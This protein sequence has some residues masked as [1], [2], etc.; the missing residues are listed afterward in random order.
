MVKEER[1]QAFTTVTADVSDNIEFYGEFGVTMNTA[2]RS[3]SPSFP[4]VTFPFVPANNPGN[5]LGVPAIM[6][7]RILGN[8][9]PENISDHNNDTYRAVAALSG[10]FDNNWSGNLSV[11]YSWHKNFFAVSDQLTDRTNAAL[12]GFGG[13]GGD[14]FLMPFL[15]IPNDPALIDYVT[16]RFQITTETSLLTVDAVVTGEIFEMPAGPLGIAIGAQYRRDDLKADAD[17]DFNN[18]NFV[19]I[20]GG[21]DIDADQDVFAFFTELSIPLHETAELQAAI[22]Y[23]D[24]G[25]GPGDT[26]DPKIALLWAP[27]DEFS[28]RASFSTSFRA[29]TVMQGQGSI[30]VVSQIFDPLAGSTFFLP[31]ITGGNPDLVPEEADV[32]NVGFS[33][34][35]VTDFTLNLDYWRFE[36]SGIIAVQDAQGIV[37]ANPFDPRIVRGPSGLISRIDTAFINAPS[38]DTDGFDISASYRFEAEGAGNFRLGLDATYVNEYKF[39]VIP[40]GP[41]FEGA[42]QRNFGAFPRSIPEWRGNVSLS[43]LLG[44]HGAAVYVRYIDSYINE[45]ADENGVPDTAI[46][47]HVTVDVQYNYTLPDFVGSGSVLSFGAINVFDNDIPAISTLGGFDSKVHDPRGRVVY[48]KFRQSF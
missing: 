28:L 31:I 16:G 10:D 22:R 34:E 13:P 9:G 11:G 15:G 24:Y 38:V 36:Y 39:S 7:G 14:Q 23:E 5:F 44:G 6:I 19:F 35:P 48:L 25:T 45:Q 32:F 21:P 40:G 42:G 4:G 18:N 20:F 41:T 26:L 12:N 30:T 33:W 27:M 43:W 46:P 1:F 37:T 3:N 47:S 8:D 17:E 29:P 2:D